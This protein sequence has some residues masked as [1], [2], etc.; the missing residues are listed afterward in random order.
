MKLSMLIILKHTFPS[1]DE[2]YAFSFHFGQ[3]LVCR[4]LDFCNSDIWI[5]M[6]NVEFFLIAMEYLT[7][8]ELLVTLKL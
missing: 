6:L 2:A 7:F 1:P 8:E 5:A 4:C 3:K